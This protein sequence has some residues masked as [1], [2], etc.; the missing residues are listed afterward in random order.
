[1]QVLCVCHS[2]WDYMSKY[3]LFQ[4]SFSDYPMILKESQ[5]WCWAR[6]CLPTASLDIGSILLS[7]EAQFWGLP[8]SKVDSCWQWQKVKGN[9]GVER[10]EERQLSLELLLFPSTKL[11]VTLVGG[12]HCG[13]YK[14]M[15]GNDGRKRK[16]TLVFFSG[17]FFSSPKQH[18]PFPLIWQQ[19]ELY[20]KQHEWLSQ[21]I[22]EL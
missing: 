11:P 3:I 2:T 8:V 15:E 20:R 22:I 6:S 17:S 10:P 4:T 7:T 21:R 13:K 16:L 1:M 12:M 9:K 18:F 14:K 19:D 5:S